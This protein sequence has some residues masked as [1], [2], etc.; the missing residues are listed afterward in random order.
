[1]NPLY[2]HCIY[3]YHYK[4]KEYLF[5]FTF[6]LKYLGYLGYCRASIQHSDLFLWLLFT[7]HYNL[8]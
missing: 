7:W 2:I 8:S 4:D 1:M 6:E 5:G 3:M